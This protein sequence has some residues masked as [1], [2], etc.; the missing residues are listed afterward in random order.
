[1][2]YNLTR[3]SEGQELTNRVNRKEGY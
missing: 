1:L 3:L 2:E